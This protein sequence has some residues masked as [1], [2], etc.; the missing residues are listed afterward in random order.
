MSRLQT[1]EVPTELKLSA[2]WVATVLCYIYCDYFALYV[3]GKVQ[4]I[5]EGRG[6]FGP[7]SELSLLGAS[8]LLIVPSVMTLLS[9]VLPA[10][11][12][13]IANL[14]SGTIYTIIM[15]VLAFAATWYFYKFYAV[16]EAALTAAVVWI[17]WKWPRIHGAV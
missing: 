2:A 3:P 1:Y 8:V 10:T 17:A 9:L 16:V 7:V 4:G 15:V 12:S 5:L 6:P 14:V 11:A 13:R